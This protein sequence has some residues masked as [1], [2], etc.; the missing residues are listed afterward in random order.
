MKEN[1]F[2]FY[3]NPTQSD[4]NIEYNGSE[5]MKIQ[6][7]SVNGQTVLDEIAIEPYSLLLLHT[8]FEKGAY[9]ISTK[10]SSGNKENYRL[11]VD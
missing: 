8:D 4:L 3:P 11:I 10:D 7:V 1:S 6:I 9:L 5:P 2:R